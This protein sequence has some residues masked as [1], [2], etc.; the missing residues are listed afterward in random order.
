VSFAPPNVA[1]PASASH[2]WLLLLL[3]LLLPLFCFGWLAENVWNRDGLTCDVSILTAIHRHATPVRDVLMVWVT[4]AGGVKAV[5]ALAVLTVVVLSRKAVWRH[6]AF[7]AGAVGGAL[8]LDWFIKNAIHRIRPHLWL[9]PA[10]EFDFG[11]PSG[12]ATG[13]MALVLALGMIAW[14]TRWRYTALFCGALYVGSVGFSRLYLGVHY[15]SD[16]LGGWILSFALVNGLIL[17]RRISVADSRAVRTKQFLLCA[18]SGLAALL[19]VLAGY[20]LSDLKHDNLRVVVPG[21]VYRAGLMST[22]ALAGCIEKYG[23]KSILNLRG[24]GKSWEW[25]GHELEAAKQLNVAHY[26]FGIS[27]RQEL[28]DSELARLEQILHDAPQP[29]LIHCDGGADRSALAS[30]IYLYAIA[31]KP[32]EEA[33]RELSPWNGHLPILWPKVIAME[34]SFRRCVTNHVSH[35]KVT[36]VPGN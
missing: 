30:A 21:E 9:S 19:A 1:A 28:T 24:E 11:F 33:E 18:A 17:A 27:A 32:P 7:L 14:R 36:G 16:V 10:P 2:R 29:V 20:I 31:G 6:A 5:L 25:Y 35:A 34:N 26:D 3:G 4:R 13:T 12:H 23:I 22:N 8:L 15:P